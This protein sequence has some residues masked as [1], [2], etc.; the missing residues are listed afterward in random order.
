MPRT[1]SPKLTLRSSAKQKLRQ[2]V[3]YEAIVL[4][5]L[6]LMGS[7]ATFY[8]FVER[9]SWLDAFYFT[10]MTLATVGYGDITPKTN[11][12]K[13]FTMFYVFLGITIFVVLAR[14]IINGLFL[15]AA[16]RRKSR[17]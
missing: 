12:G 3:P 16:Q 1:P 7:G 17:K 4:T 14:L 6:V 5:M 10:T 15:R 11:A 8:H 2:N 9:I 13:V